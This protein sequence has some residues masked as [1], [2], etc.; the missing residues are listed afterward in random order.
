MPRTATA[1]SIESRIASRVEKR[2]RGAVFIPAD[3]LDLGS[4]QAVD[5]ALHRLVKKGTLRRLARGL[6][7]YPKTHPA[8]GLI[9]P[10]V[11][12]IAKALAGKHK[13]RLRP[14]GAYAANM[15]RL[16]E[17]IPA[18]VVFLTDG[19]TR[20]VR[21]RNQTI[22]LRRTTPR[23]MAADGTTSL[24]IE[25]LRNLG[26]AHVT[27][28]RVAHLRDL[29]SAT[30]RTQLLENLPLAPAWMHPFMRFIAEGEPSATRGRPRARSA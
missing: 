2:G 8:L 18:K 15:L 28:E 6:Y 30:D 9:A 13:I 17:Q 10:A 12:D 16:S 5:L 26:K 1:D 29:L 7:D 27:R 22:E 19:P 11:D 4:R 21:I 14:S 20:K 3:F 23:A 25:G 24:V